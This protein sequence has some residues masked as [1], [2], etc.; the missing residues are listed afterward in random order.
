[1]AFALEQ[2]RANDE[3]GGDA[4]DGGGDCQK[5]IASSSS[6]GRDVGPRSQEGVRVGAEREFGDVVGPETHHATI[7]RLLV[8]DERADST[9]VHANQVVRHHDRACGFY[10]RTQM[11]CR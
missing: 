9:A 6:F 4:C 5:A 2:D 11:Y 1:M 10:P 3:G 7:R 8:L